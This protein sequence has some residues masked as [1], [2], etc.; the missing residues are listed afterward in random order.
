MIPP[1]FNAFEF[2]N[3]QFQIIIEFE[4]L[5]ERIPAL[6]EEDKLLKLEDFKSKFRDKFVFIKHPSDL[7]YRLVIFTL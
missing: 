7:H 6:D 3:T 4:S 2:K 5:I 1:K